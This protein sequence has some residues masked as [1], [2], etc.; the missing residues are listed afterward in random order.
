[1]ENV[2]KSWNEWIENLQ[3]PITQ[4]SQKWNSL[5]DKI[6]GKMRDYIQKFAK[7]I[8]KDFRD[9][10]ELKIISEY[11]EDYIDLLDKNTNKNI[12]I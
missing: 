6:E 9:N 7:D 8:T 10:F 1:M 5:Q 4:K 11:L 3:E 2:L 12:N